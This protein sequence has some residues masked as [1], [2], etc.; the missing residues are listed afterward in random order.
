MN[1]ENMDDAEK[2]IHKE[3]KSQY[4]SH[5]CNRPGEVRETYSPN[6][7][8][9][10]QDGRVS[11]RTAQIICVMHTGERECVFFPVECG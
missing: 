11:L 2:D 5:H 3:Q 8:P 9:Q 6:W 4:L 10:A 1:W 7:A